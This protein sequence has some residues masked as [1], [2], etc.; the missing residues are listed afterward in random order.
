M[1]TAKNVPNLGIELRTE[2]LCIL[3]AIQIIIF[4]IS[5]HLIIKFLY[6]DGLSEEFYLTF[7]D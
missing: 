1:K 6:L 4:I 5:Y 7:N 2:Y 3:T